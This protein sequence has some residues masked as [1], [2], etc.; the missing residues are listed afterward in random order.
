MI[1]DREEAA[2]KFHYTF[3]SKQLTP[4]IAVLSDGECGD[5]CGGAVVANEGG[6][7]R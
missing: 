1:N 3:Y 5:E 2:S 6:R 7:C 4:C